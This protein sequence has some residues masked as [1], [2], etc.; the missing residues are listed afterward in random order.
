MREIIIPAQTIHKHSHTHKINKM[1]MFY[2]W[3]LHS[4]LQSPFLPIF[5]NRFAF[6]KCLFIVIYKLGHFC[7]TA[8]FMCSVNKLSDL[9]IDVRLKHIWIFCRSTGTSSVFA[10]LI[11]KHLIEPVWLKNSSSASLRYYYDE[12]MDY[13]NQ[14]WTPWRWQGCAELQPDKLDEK[15][16]ESI[17]P[18]TSAASQHVDH[19]PSAQFA[20]RPSEIFHFGPEAEIEFPVVI[21]TSTRWG[22]S[23]CLRKSSELLGASYAQNGTESRFWV[24]VKSSNEIILTYTVYVCVCVCVCVSEEFFHQPVWPFS[25]LIAVCFCFHSISFLFI[26][27][28]SVLYS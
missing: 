5:R 1:A 16:A 27:F 15:K 11:N 26:M 22:I 12:H 21:Y 18:E 19:F 9:E 14:F 2:S 10:L 20:P 6:P 3:W 13:F 4:V 7:Q 24:I 28:W 23:R 8:T 25:A 17:L